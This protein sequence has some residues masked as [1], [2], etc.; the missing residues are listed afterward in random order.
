M[1]VVICRI[2]RNVLPAN[3]VFPIITLIYFNVS[4]RIKRHSDV[5]RYTTMFD[6]YDL[7]LNKHPCFIEMATK[8]TIY[9]K[10]KIIMPQSELRSPVSRRQHGLAYGLRVGAGMSVGDRHNV[11]RS[12][13]VEC[14]SSKSEDGDPL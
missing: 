5:K 7:C 2:F 11:N 4:L 10:K 8:S 9:P 3:L 1:F 13:A 6:S 14:R 12:L